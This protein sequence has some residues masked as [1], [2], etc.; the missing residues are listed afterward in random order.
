M[1]RHDDDV[2]EDTHEIEPDRVDRIPPHTETG[3]EASIGDGGR[4]AI[5]TYR[6]NINMGIDG[7]T[8]SMTGDRVAYQEET[9]NVTM[10]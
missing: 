5:G 3:V 2:L 7:R 8:E 1:L 9:G 4:N 10:R 6:Q